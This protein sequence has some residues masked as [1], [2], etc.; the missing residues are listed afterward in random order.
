MNTQQRNTQS[1]RAILLCVGVEQLANSNAWP[2]LSLFKRLR[3]W[4]MTK[5]REKNRLYFCTCFERLCFC[6]LY[7]FLLILWKLRE[8]TIRFHDIFTSG[9]YM[10]IFGVNFEFLIMPNEDWWLFFVKWDSY[11]LMICIFAWFSL[12]TVIFTFICLYAHILCSIT[13]LIQCIHCQ[14]ET[15]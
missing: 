12:F 9:S 14:T 11:V 15:L 10:P 4:D 2:I 7:S 8:I 6:Y 1:H 13:H 3:R 5:M